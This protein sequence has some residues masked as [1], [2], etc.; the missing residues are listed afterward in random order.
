[1]LMGSTSSANPNAARGMGRATPPEN[2]DPKRLS[3]NQA[4]EQIDAM[5][6]AGGALMR[7]NDAARRDGIIVAQQHRGYNPATA[8]PTAGTRC[9]SS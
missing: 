8:V 2:T 4:A 9:D 6:V 5:L 3:L 1:M 7:V